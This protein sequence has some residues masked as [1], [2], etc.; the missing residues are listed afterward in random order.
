M[1]KYRQWDIPK[2]KQKTE[3]GQFFLSRQDNRFDVWLQCFFSSDLIDGERQQAERGTAREELIAGLCPEGPARLP[4]G[5]P[6]PI[7][8]DC[9]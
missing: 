6:L 1:I 3:G 2:K 4:E 9:R 7:R 5:D 8:S